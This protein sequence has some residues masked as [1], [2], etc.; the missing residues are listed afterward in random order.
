MQLTG[1]RVWVF[2][3]LMHLSA[4]PPPEAKRPFWWGLHPIALTAAVC[5]ENLTRGCSPF[6]RLHTINLLSLPP[7]ASCVSSNDHLKPHTSCLC[8]T[9]FWKNWLFA[10]KSLCKIFLSLD[11]V[12]TIDPFHATVP[13]L[14]RWPE[15]VLTS[16][17]WLVSQIWVSPLFVPTARWEPL[18][19]QPTEVIESSIGTSQS[20]VT[21]LVHALQMYTARPKPTASTFEDD[22][23]TRLR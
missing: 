21:L 5:S 3:N 7:D 2:Q 22:Q 18:W 23:S 16:L 9:S 15:S 12:L 6:Y 10:L 13:T 8:P 1:C 19:L 4:V 14:L 20:F 11:P 17:Q